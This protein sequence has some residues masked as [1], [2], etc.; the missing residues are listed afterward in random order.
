MGT[1]ENTRFQERGA[2]HKVEFPLDIKYESIEFNLANGQSDYDLAVQ[3]ITA[4]V[5]L[6]VWTSVFIRTN[7]D[8]S[9]K[10]NATTNHVI[11]IAEYES[12][13]HLVSEIEIS[14]IYLTNASGATAAIKLLAFHRARTHA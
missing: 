12:P 2:A 14:N 1:P 5:T 4:F 10:L 8:I 3:Q 11:S 9:I 7:K 13:F 6:G